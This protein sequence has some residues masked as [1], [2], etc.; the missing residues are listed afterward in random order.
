M[1]STRSWKELVAGGFAGMTAP[2]GVHPID[3]RRASRML[4]A[5]NVQGASLDQVVAEALRHLRRQGVTGDLL[6]EEERRIRTFSPNPM[7]KTKMSRAWLVTLEEMEKKS[8][9]VSVFRAQRSAEKVREYMEQ[10]YIDKYYDLQS[11]LVY[12][13]SVRH[14]PY[15]AEFERLDGVQ[16]QGRITCGHNPFLLGRIVLNLQVFQHGAKQIPEWQELPA[17][18]ANAT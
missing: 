11:K 1:A 3:K 5:A 18:N 10:W 8:K 4:H 14:N 17:R 2:F 16:W 9:V 15:P 6:R 13:K 12:A 7:A